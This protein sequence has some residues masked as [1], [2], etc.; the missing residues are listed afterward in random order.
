MQSFKI[1]KVRSKSFTCTSN[2]TSLRRF[3]HQLFWW[4]N[5]STSI[6]EHPL[7]CLASAEDDIEY[8]SSTTQSVV[9][10]TSLARFE[11]TL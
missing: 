3:Y 6:T 5:I 2:K 1:Q 4:K 7:K 9:H 11:S 10:R 8:W